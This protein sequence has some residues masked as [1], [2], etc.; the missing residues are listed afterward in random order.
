MYYEVDFPSPQQFIL[1]RD[2]VQH[3]GCTHA[4][5]AKRTG[6]NAA[7]V[8]VGIGALAAKGWIRRVMGGRGRAVAAKRAVQLIRLVERWQEQDAKKGAA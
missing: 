1:L 6:L 2:I 5:R 4:E 7:S 3:S 8:G